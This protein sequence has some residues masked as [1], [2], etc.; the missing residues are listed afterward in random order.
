MTNYRSFIVVLSFWVMLLGSC[1]KLIEVKLPVNQI[2]SEAVF[3]SDATATAAML[4]VYTDMMSSPEQYSSG[5]LTYYGGLCADELLPY[6]PGAKD[7]FAGNNISPANDALLYGF[8]QPA[9]RHIYACNAIIENLRTSGS[10]SPAVRNN[11]LGEACFIRAFCLYQLVNLF[12][13]IPLVLHTRFQENQREKRTGIT[14]I[15]DQIMTD[16]LE[17]KKLLGSNYVS[18][19]RVRPNSFA[20]SVM[21]ARVLALRGEWS[22]VEAET[23]TVIAAPVY[24]LSAKPQEVFLK[25]SQETIWQLL[26]VENLLSS[27]EANQ[28]LPATPGSDINYHIRPELIQSFESGDQRRNAWIDSAYLSGSWY[29]IPSKYKALYGSPQ[30]E[31]YVVLRLAECYLL[32]AEARAHLNNFSGASADVSKVRQRASLPPV[33][34]TDKTILLATIAGER[35][36]ELMLEWGH[37]WFDLKRT[38]KA[39]EALAAMKGSNWQASDLLW[40][41]PQAEINLNPFLTQN[42]GY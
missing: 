16:L 27:W 17:A 32:R 13:D 12:G 39:T 30:T 25:Q 41:I 28:F 1:R 37:R 33:N 7:E 11:L 5:Y 31:N 21:L 24:S 42:P 3:K 9:Y 26:P 10:V 2:T 29:F 4:G 14:S 18:A 8:W 35:R 6:F 22:S 36:K 40:P 38:G 20:A 19:G 34:I 23:S 15:L